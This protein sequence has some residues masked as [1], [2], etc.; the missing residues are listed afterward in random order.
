MLR[1]GIAIALGIVVIYIVGG[2]RQ[3]SL[4]MEGSVQVLLPYLPEEP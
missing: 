3:Y 1:I 4:R 2:A